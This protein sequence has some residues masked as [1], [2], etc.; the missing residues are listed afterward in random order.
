MGLTIRTTRALLLLFTSS[1]S[2]YTLVY[3]TFS[4]AKATYRSVERSKTNMPAEADDQ[5]NVI[6]VLTAEDDSKKDLVLLDTGASV[7]IVRSEWGVAH[8]HAHRRSLI[9]WLK[10]STRETKLCGTKTFVLQSIAGDFTNVEVQ[11]VL[12]KM[13][14]TISIF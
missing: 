12:E 3:P 5:L 8:V 11:V 9:G 1:I 10:S 14:D 4:G 6:E 7:S 13:F 2:I